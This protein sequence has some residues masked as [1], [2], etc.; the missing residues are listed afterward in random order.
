MFGGAE[1]SKETGVETQGA[2]GFDRRRWELVV[3][4]PYARRFGMKML[5]MTSSETVNLGRS[6]TLK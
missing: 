6:S 1:R 4:V 3:G 5:A 2:A